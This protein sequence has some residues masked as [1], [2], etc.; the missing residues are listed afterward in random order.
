[1]AYLKRK[2]DKT[3]TLKLKIERRD[4]KGRIHTTHLKENVSMHLDIIEKL[5]NKASRLNVRP[6]LIESIW[7]N[8]Y[9]REE[10]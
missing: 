4:K 5:V 1:M 7:N 3:I 8:G 6:E 9:K 10:D 2:E